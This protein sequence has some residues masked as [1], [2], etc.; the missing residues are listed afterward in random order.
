MCRRITIEQPRRK[1][2]IDGCSLY[3]AGQEGMTT[4]EP[5]SH[6][7]DP[8]NWPEA[9]GQAHRMLDDL[10][11][12][13]EGLRAGPVWQPLPTEVRASFDAPLPYEPSGIEEAHEEFLR[14]VLPYSTG[15]LHP[16]FMGW[17][18]GGGNLAGML[19]EMLAGGL[20]ANLG[21]RD[22]APIEVERQVLRWVR[23]IFGFPETASGLF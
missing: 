19:G 11:D 14:N 2:S 9:R 4:T 16:S 20:N 5:A 21:G 6:S 12:H 15:N 3:V 23:R 17:V 1:V 7:L 13:I 8:E 18:H 10:L 22:H